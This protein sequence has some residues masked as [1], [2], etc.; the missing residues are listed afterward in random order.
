MGSL[1]CEN[2]GFTTSQIGQMPVIYL[3]TLHEILS[4]TTGA[5]VVMMRLCVA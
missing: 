4:Q 3:I 5:D 2:G 1:L